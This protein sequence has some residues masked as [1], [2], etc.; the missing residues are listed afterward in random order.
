MHEQSISAARDT[1]QSHQHKRR[2]N[3]AC[4][5]LANPKN[6]TLR[7]TLSP[8]RMTHR[9]APSSN[10]PSTRLTT[11]AAAPPPMARLRSTSRSSRAPTQ[12]NLASPFS[13]CRARL[14][15]VGTP[16]HA[17]P[18][19]AY[20]RCSRWPRWPAT[21]ACRAWKVF[22]SSPAAMP[23]TPSSCWRTKAEHHAIRLSTPAPSSSVNG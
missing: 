9:F 5:R 15:C 6:Q 22:P 23:S 21:A 16:T 19:K 18:C 17:S 20:P 4:V 8:P 12:H 3:S 1:P 10:Q 7:G 2:A 14:W 13:R 11:S